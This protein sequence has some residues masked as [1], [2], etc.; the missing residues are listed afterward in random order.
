MIKLGGSKKVRQLGLWPRKRKEQIYRTNRKISQSFLRVESK[1]ELVVGIRYVILRAAC[2]VARF[3]AL[4]VLQSFNC[5]MVMERKYKVCLY[6]TNWHIHFTFT[7]KFDSIITY[8]CSAGVFVG[9]VCFRVSF[10][11]INYY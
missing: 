9:D 1:S 11:I 10:Y 3:R 6:A 8:S 2:V 4:L 7:L 5:S